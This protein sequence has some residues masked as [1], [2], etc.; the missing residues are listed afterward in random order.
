MCTTCQDLNK[1]SQVPLFLKWNKLDGFLQFLFIGGHENS[2]NKGKSI[3]E[4]KVN[5]REKAFCDL[6]DTMHL[7]AKT[8]DDTA[9]SFSEP[10]RQMQGAN[11]T[12]PL[13]AQ[14]SQLR[15]REGKKGTNTSNEE[16]YDFIRNNIYQN[17]NC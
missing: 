9:H 7:P 5:I 14:G 13:P 8:S 4:A 1:D 6:G 3:S 17:I 2:Q 11:T 15:E 12:K 10:Q 16:N